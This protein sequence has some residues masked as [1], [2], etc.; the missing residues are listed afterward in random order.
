MRDSATKAPA[1]EQ[2]APSSPCPP[3]AR[4]H[5]LSFKQTNKE[6]RASKYS[7]HGRTTPT[8][9]LSHPPGWRSGA[10]GG[11]AAS[12]DHIK[13]GN[14]RITLWPNPLTR[15]KPRGLLS[16]TTIRDTLIGVLRPLLKTQTPVKAV[17]PTKAHGLLP[18]WK[19][20]KNSKKPSV[21]P[22][23][24]PLEPTER[25]PPRSRVPLRPV[26]QS[27]PRSRVADLPS[28]R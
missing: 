22:I 19:K 23:H 25:S 8:G 27:P 1:T 9:V 12:F 21:R 2:R 7:P 6:A 26:G 14:R 17:G 3:S 28:N 16:G 15:P 5:V 18:T 24:I 10:S 4:G 11:C 13:R 20:A